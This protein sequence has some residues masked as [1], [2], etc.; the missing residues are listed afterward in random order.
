GRKRVAIIQIFDG[1]LPVQIVV[2]R[3]RLV[4]SAPVGLNVDAVRETVLVYRRYE[5]AWVIDRS[6]IE[7]PELVP[8]FEHLFRIK[9]AVFQFAQILAHKSRS[10]F[11]RKVV[12]PHVL[13]D[14]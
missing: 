2:L 1:E 14:S 12:P 4:L 9:K 5:P 13:A 11:L 10:N 8:T 6:Q 3:V 7:K